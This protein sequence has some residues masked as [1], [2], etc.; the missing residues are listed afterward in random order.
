P[1]PTITPT[2]IPHLST[3]VE[4]QIEVAPL[5]YSVGD[6]GG[7]TITV[8]NLLDRDVYIKSML[9]WLPYNT[10]QFFVID[11]GTCDLDTGLFGLGQHIA[12]D[13]FIL[14]ASESGS[15]VFLIS[16]KEAGNYEGEVSVELNP[17]SDFYGIEEDAIWVEI[18]VTP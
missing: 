7:I 15:M 2:P 18:V 4:V 1:T 11:P 14:P 3:A 10:L 5:R 12:C 17:G 8:T 13:E 9:I 16:P 6:P